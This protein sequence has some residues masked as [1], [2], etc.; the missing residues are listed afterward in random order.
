MITFVDHR[1]GE[2]ERGNARAL[3]P[4]DVIE[5]T[6]GQ[7]IAKY[8]VIG[9]RREGDLLPQPLPG[10]EGRLELITADGSPLLPS[11]VIHIDADLTTNAW[12]TPAAV[13]TEEVLTPAEF[14][15]AADPSAWFSTLFWAQLLIASLD[16]VNELGKHGAE[17]TGDVDQI[18]VTVLEESPSVRCMKLVFWFIHR[19]TS[20]DT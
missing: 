6:T 19:E 10:G 5:I 11:G 18:N 7:G 2:V 3:E 9:V 17:T 4:G 12:D 14:P 13:L 20:S 8:E 1:F 16:P 15:M